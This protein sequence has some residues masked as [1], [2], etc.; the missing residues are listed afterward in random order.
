MTNRPIAFIVDDENLVASTFELIL[1]SKGFNARSFVDPLDAL[2]AARTT[3]PHLLLTD[4]MM[5]N[6]N[7][8]EL[9]QHIRQL[10][11]SCSVLLLS[12]EPAAHRILSKAASQGERFEILAK[13]VH[14]ETMLEKIQELLEANR[15]G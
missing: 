1:M 4:V 8:I 13:P 7:G 12:G 3:K 2:E 14:P 10:H 9:A 15:V 11:P 5:P 6:M